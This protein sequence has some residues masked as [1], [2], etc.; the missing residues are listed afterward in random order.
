MAY[1]DSNYDSRYK[2]LHRLMNSNNNNNTYTRLFFGSW[3][4]AGAFNLSVSNYKKQLEYR[5]IIQNPDRNIFQKSGAW[6]KGMYGLY[7]LEDNWFDMRNDEM[8]QSIS[9]LNQTTPGY[10]VFVICGSR[11]PVLA[12]FNVLQ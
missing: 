10:Q 11:A 9:N 5:N 8:L 6:V 12:S 4:H 3:D 2:K 7:A 1:I